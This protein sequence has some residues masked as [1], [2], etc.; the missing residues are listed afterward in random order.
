M[1]KNFSDEVLKFKDE[2]LKLEEIKK[3]LEAF[4]SN[5][6]KEQIFKANELINLFKQSKLKD[7]NKI[8]KT[9]DYI[10]TIKLFDE[11]K[12]YNHLNNSHCFKYIFYS[13]IALIK[14]EE[15]EGKIDENSLLQISTEKFNQLKNIFENNKIESIGDNIKCLLDL[16]LNSI[17]SLNK[18]ILFL[19]RYFNINVEEEREKEIKSNIILFARTNKI[20]YILLGLKQLFELFKEQINDGQEIMQKVENYTEEIKD[21]KIEI[22]KIEEIISFFKKFNIYVEDEDK[23]GNNIYI[24]DNNKDEINKIRDNIKNKDIFFTFLKLIQNNPDPIIFAKSKMKI[25]AK[26]LLDF[27]LESDSKKNLQ[28]NDVQGFIKT[29]E[30]F[31]KDRENKYNLTELIKNLNNALT[32]PNQENYI[33]DFIN[34]YIKNYNGIKALY[35]ESLN[36]SDTSSLIISLILRNSEI[37]V[38][39]NSFNIEYYNKENVLTKM[40]FEEIE[41]LRGKA[42]IMKS[43]MKKEEGKIVDTNYFNVRKFVDL[44]QN[45]KT[46]N[47]YLNDLFNIELPEP[48]KYIISIKIA[49]DKIRRIK[50]NENNNYDYSDIICKMCKKEFSLKNLIDYLY[51]LKIGIQNLTERCYLENDYIRFFYGKTFEFINRNLK[52]KNYKNLLPI[53]QSLT[54]NKISNIIDDFN[55]DLNST[56]VFSDFNYLQELKEEED[57]FEEKEDNAELLKGQKEEIEEIKEEEKKEVEE[58]KEEEKKEVEEIR[59]EEKEKN[60]IEKKEEENAIK[61]NNEEIRNNAEK[62]NIENLDVLANNNDNIDPIIFSFN[63]MMYNISEYCKRLFKKNGIISCEDIYKINE[64]KDIEEIEKFTSVFTSTVSEKNNDKKLFIYYKELSK[65]IPNLSSLLICNEETKKEEII[66]FLFRVFLCPC[67]TLFVISKSDTLTKFNK[68]FL[69]EKVNEFLK[70]YKNNMKSIL[71]IFHSDDKSEIKKGFNNI[72]EVK[73]FQ[74]KF[75]ND[76]YKPDYINKVEKLKKI[77][78]VQSERCGEGKSTFI[79]LKINNS[80]KKYIYFQIGGVFTR[81]TL[82]ERLKNQIKINNEKTQYVLHID[83][84]Y[85]ELNDLAL[86]FLFKFLIMKYYNSDNNIFCYNLNQFE[87]FIEIHNEIYNLEKYQIL[88]YYL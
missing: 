81:Q 25:N 38:T 68:I 41:E 79:K 2:I 60:K 35:N 85:T 33:G 56:L 9:P 24:E 74:S 43:Y 86:E 72:K 22:K 20:N 26:L 44:I 1:Y 84:T 42:L 70:A 5:S 62:D 21:P 36:K 59:E 8:I 10:E 58:K 50:T 31:D 32:V 65:S 48:E 39:Y 77:T 57:Y 52:N 80:R 4:F 66:S 64:I 3:Y 49:F 6:K 19:K 47:N 71:I 83:L 28:E 63:N 69:I 55:Y 82:F 78:V 76:I 12:I 14:K 87:I 18:E 15:K 53:F 73:S 17:E 45:F 67:P 40:E 75:E 7:Y 34:K 30:F 27:L 37:K 11:S 16:A 54:N 13:Q 61:E 46:L 88:K 23:E 29:V 51:K